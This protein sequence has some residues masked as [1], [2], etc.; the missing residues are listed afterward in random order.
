MALTDSKEKDTGVNFS[1]HLKHAVNVRRPGE[2]HVRRARVSTT[3]HI[4]Q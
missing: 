1:E 2:N 4:C 3:L